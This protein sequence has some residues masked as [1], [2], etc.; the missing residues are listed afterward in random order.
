M[1]QLPATLIYK[2]PSYW[3]HLPFTHILERLISRTHPPNPGTSR[4]LLESVLS[5]QVIYPHGPLQKPNT[6]Q[7]YYSAQLQREVRR[8][9]LGPGKQSASI[10][11]GPRSQTIA[12]EH[13]GQRHNDKHL[14]TSFILAFA[15]YW[16]SLS[17][18]LLP[19]QTNWGPPRSMMGH[20]TP[21]GKT[22]SRYLQKMLG[23]RLK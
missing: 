12:N 13:T 16:V 18:W 19:L 8:E 11:L 10:F 17:L 2:R 15:R 21:L 3:S 14:V 5:S 22:R 9:F 4:P 1:L 23:H 6:N 20:R 7:T